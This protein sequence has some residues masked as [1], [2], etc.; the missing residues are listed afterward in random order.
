MIYAPAKV[1][2]AVSY[3]LG[4]DAFTRKHIF[5]TFDLDPGLIGVKV[6]QNVAQFPLHHMTYA[7][8][9]FEVST[10]NTLDGDTFA[11][12]YMHVF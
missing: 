3:S 2:V 8:A 9:K 4:G 1:E 7:P 12:K 11:R 5:F 10:S 6:I